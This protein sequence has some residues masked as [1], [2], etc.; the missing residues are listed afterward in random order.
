MAD[1]STDLIQ[2]NCHGYGGVR[3]A[4]KYVNKD[5]LSDLFQIEDMV[6]VDQNG[7]EVIADEEGNLPSVSPA[8]TYIVASEKDLASD[9]ETEEAGHV[10]GCY[11]LFR[12]FNVIYD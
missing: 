10:C 4:R 5:V 2:F 7:D 9:D 1:T 6:I 12:V 8:M 3:L 11:I